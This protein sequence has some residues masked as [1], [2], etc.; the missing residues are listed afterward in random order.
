MPNFLGFG[1]TAY[2]AI[3]HW[4]KAAVYTQT[5]SRVDNE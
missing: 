5:G 2:V 3:E 1:E 4:R